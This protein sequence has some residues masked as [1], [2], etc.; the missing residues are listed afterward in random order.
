M[1]IRWAYRVWPI[2]EHHEAYDIIKNA[3]NKI[4][5]HEDWE[6]I[7]SRINWQEMPSPKIHKDDAHAEDN[8]DNL[9][10]TISMTLDKNY[11]AHTIIFNQTQYGNYH[12]DYFNYL[13][14]EQHG[15]G[16]PGEEVNDL[17]DGFVISEEDYNKH[18]HHIPKEKL[19]GLSIKHALQWGDNGDAVYFRSNNLHS[20]GAS[21]EG[22]YKVAA[23][24]LI[25]LY[26]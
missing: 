14:G 26:K 11:D 3:I 17:E 10:Y 21:I 8:P 1:S 5:G 13:N 24:T 2:R 15:Q 4:V 19:R 25:K 18:L 9:R 6:W 20:P 22:D 12:F 16:E 7:G 23:A